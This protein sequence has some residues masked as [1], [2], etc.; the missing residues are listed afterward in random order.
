M[1]NFTM[2]IFVALLLSACQ[3]TQTQ[4][5]AQSKSESDPIMGYDKVTWGTSIQDV[6]RAYGISN[7]IATTTTSYNSLNAVNLVQEDVSESIERRV[8]SFL[9]NKLCEVDV[10]YKVSSVTEQD[11]YNALKVKFGESTGHEEEKVSISIFEYTIFGKYSPELVVYLNKF[12]TIFEE[13]EELF[14]VSYI[15]QRF[16]DEHEASKVEL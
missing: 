6:R 15:G 7:N 10:V 13:A 5:Q 3:K 9:E 12:Y 2:L 4:T 8:F 16:I 14:S 1:K 11:L